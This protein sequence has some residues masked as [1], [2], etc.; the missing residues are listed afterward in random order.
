MLTGKDK[1]DKSLKIG[2]KIKALVD[3]V[4]KQ[5]I[6][7]EVICFKNKTYTVCDIGDDY[8]HV[9]DAYIVN[10]KTNNGVLALSKDEIE[11]I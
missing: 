10:E 3:K 7:G 2:S 9:D 6:I 4:E 5:N 8:I 11:I 1:Y